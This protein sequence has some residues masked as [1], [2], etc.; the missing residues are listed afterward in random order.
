M[1]IGIILGLLECMSDQEGRVR[2]LLRKETKMITI[3]VE[4]YCSTCMDF[5]PDVQLPEK[6][7]AKN[8]EIVI[9]DTIIRCSHRNRCKNIERHLRLQ[10]ILD[11]V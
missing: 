8:E 1:N 4:E 10:N 5:E 11:Q 7:Y 6:L 9:S 2:N 3:D